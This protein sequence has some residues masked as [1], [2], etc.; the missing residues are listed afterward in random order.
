LSP[1]HGCHAGCCRA[2]AVPVTGAEILRMERALGL[3]F[4]QLA[5]RWEDRDDAISAGVAPQFRFEDDSSIPYVIC[6]LHEPSRTFP[7]T[8][9]CRFLIEQP[10]T[11]D[12]PLGR[13]SCGIYDARPLPCRVYPTKLSESGSLAVLHDV[14]V[15]GRAND[16]S[17]AFD[18]CGR[19]WEVEDVDSIAAVQDLVVLRFELQFFRQ[20]AALWNRAPGRWEDFPE[21]LRLVYRHRVQARPVAADTKE[22]GGMRGILKFPAAGDE[23]TSDAIAA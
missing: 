23:S 12:A 7:R 3:D 22:T 1:C 9:K 17:P 5:C 11:A 14:P 4:W 6:L 19:P 10:P 21:F 8:T 2:F 13:A 20:V 18:L 16:P 15:H